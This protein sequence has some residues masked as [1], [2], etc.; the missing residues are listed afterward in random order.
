MDSADKHETRLQQLARDAFPAAGLA[1]AVAIGGT[2]LG[3][4]DPIGYGLMTLAVGLFTTPLL[5]PTP[6]Q[7]VPTRV[8]TRPRR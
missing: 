1:L 3:M 4:A 8:R 7:M 5:Q 2:L 6:R